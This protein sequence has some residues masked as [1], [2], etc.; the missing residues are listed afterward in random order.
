M[1][2]A[3]RFTKGD[4][5]EEKNSKVWFR[6]RLTRSYAGKL[7]HSNYQWNEIWF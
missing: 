3:T 4:N 7:I 2:L 6:N 1:F 5:E